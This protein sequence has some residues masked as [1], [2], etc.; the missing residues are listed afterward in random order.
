M[1]QTL[2]T[3]Q[4]SSLTDAA[5]TYN[6]VDGS[7]GN[8]FANNGNTLAL[9]KNGGGSPI[10]ATFSSVPDQFGRTGDVAV[11]VAAGAER[12][13]GPFPVAL[14]NQTSGGNAGNVNVSFSSGTSVTM[15]LI[16][17]T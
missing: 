5:V 12:V 6:A 9:I 8:T 13:V 3:R 2:L 11:T 15:A 16:S 7:N 14:F 17:T 1:S 4:Q 10:T